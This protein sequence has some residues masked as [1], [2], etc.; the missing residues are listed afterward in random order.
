MYVRPEY[1]SNGSKRESNHVLRD[2][3]YAGAQL[4]TAAPRA[5]FVHRFVC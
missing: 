5:A 2:A 3:I 4:E 1:L